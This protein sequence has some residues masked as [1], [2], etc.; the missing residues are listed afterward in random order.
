MFHKDG[1]N[2]WGKT[3]SEGEEACMIFELDVKMGLI[4]AYEM[5]YA[6]NLT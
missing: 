2:I 3:Y 1:G 5:L 4:D 6:K